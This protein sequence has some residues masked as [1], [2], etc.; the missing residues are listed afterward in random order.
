MDTALF[1]SGFFRL[2][3]SVFQNEEVLRWGRMGEYF[4]SLCK[5]DSV[6]KVVLR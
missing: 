4:M 1:P 3:E 2:K 5:V 6:T